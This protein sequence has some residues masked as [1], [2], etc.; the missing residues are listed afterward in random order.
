MF[1]R[2]N[3]GDIFAAGGTNLHGTLTLNARCFALVY[4]HR[5]LQHREL[6]NVCSFKKQQQK[7]NQKIRGSWDRMQSVTKESNSYTYMT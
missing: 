1:D 5:A 2:G 4:T 6:T 7:I 3:S